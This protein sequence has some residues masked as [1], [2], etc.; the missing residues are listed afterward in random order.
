MKNKKKQLSKMEKAI[1]RA[2]KVMPCPTGT[3]VFKDRKKEQ[4]KKWCRRQ[5]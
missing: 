2:R 5:K 1:L 4:N 3:K